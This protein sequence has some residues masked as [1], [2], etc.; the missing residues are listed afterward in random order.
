MNKNDAFEKLFGED[1]WKGVGKGDAGEGAR[2]VRENQEL[3]RQLAA[4]NETIETLRGSKKFYQDNFGKAK[5]A[6]E[7]EVAR[8]RALEAAN[9]P[10]EVAALDEL[11]TRYSIEAAGDVTIERFSIWRKL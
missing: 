8:R 2:L 5:A 3:K 10:E 7:K 6:Y 1:F 9:S 11:I 4:A